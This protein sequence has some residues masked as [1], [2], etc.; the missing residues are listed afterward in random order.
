MLWRQKISADHILNP[1]LENVY[2]PIRE[3][4]KLHEFEANKF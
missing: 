4:Q 2:I 1:H 3:I